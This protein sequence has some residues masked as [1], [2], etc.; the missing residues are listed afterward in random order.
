MPPVERQGRMLLAKTA[1]ADSIRGAIRPCK[2]QPFA[3]TNRPDAGPREPRGKAIRRRDQLP[4]PFF[5]DGKE[6]LHA[7]HV[8]ENIR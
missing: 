4:S 1:N 2:C 5:S 8:P 7:R 3:D 6:H